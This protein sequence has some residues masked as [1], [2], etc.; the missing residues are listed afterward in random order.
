MA[1]MSRAGIDVV[2]PSPK[3]RLKVVADLAMVVI[4]VTIV[5]LTMFH[6]PSGYSGPVWMDKV[7]HAVAFFVLVL[8]GAMV[9][10]YAFLWLVPVAVIFG[11]AIEYFQPYFGRS[12]EIADLYADIAGILAGAITGTLVRRWRE[13]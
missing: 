11:A 4:A 13:S 9:H 5:F 8:P 7:Y 10:R 12:R 6:S 2:Q 3:H 1:A